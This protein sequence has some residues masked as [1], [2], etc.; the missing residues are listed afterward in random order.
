MAYDPLLPAEIVPGEPTKSE[1]F[2]KVLNNQD[3]FDTDIAALQQTATID[4]FDVKY[5]GE[6]SQYTTAE[7]NERSPMFKA[8]VSATFVSFVVTLLEASTSGTLEVEV[9]KSTDNGVNWTPLLSS[10]VTVTGT[11]VGSL[12]GAV[13]WVDVPSQSFAQNDLIRVRIP[14]LQVG[15]GAFHVSIYGELS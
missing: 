14:G 1:I 6:I 9:D 7:L 3:Q 12:S 15:Q 13:N 5:T 10:A 4:I 8:P 2:T 11:T